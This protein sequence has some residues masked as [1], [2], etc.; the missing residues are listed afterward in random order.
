VRSLE[1][2]GADEI[3]IVDDGSDPPARGATL[4][5]ERPLGPA[6]AR[7]LGWRA[8]SGD[9]VAFT[10]DDCEAAPGWLAALRRLAAP[11]TVVQGR[12]EPHPDERHQ[13]DAFARTM[14]VTARSPF[15]ATCN[16]LYPRALLERL[17]GFDERYPYPAGEDTDLG[18]RALEAGARHV[19]EPDALV[20]HAVH[21]LSW[22]EQARAASRWATAVEVVRR[23]PGLRAHLHHRIFWKPSHE[24]LLLAAAGA[25]LA[26]RT[27]GLSLVALVPWIDAHRREHPDKWSLLRGL[28]GH[29]AVDAAELWALLRG[30]AR[31][32]TLLL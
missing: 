8:A 10:D 3:V 18:W 31:A 32:R 19:F 21:T 17:G 6:A 2:Q 16:V 26:P 11:D 13:L 23:H 30:S 1:A 5:N 9:Y 24:A 25:A 28:P 22:R 15:V 20:W 7:N 12:T 27:R 29:A 4:R 14:W